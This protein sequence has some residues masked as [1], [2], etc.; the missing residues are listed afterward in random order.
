[1]YAVSSFA[2]CSRGVF[3]LLSHC[4]YLAAQWTAQLATLLS[5]DLEAI[6]TALISTYWPALLSTDRSAQHSA[7][8]TAFWATQL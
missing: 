7:Q 4:T 8:F 2:I 5:T 1:M 3:I 6:N